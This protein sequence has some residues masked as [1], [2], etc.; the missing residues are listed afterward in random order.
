MRVVKVIGGLGVAAL[1][2][3]APARLSA[4]PLKV[5]SAGSLR[6]ALGEIFAARG[7]TSADQVQSTFGSAGTLRRRLEAGEPADLFLSADMAAPLRLFQSHHGKLAPI[8]FARNTMCVMGSKALGLSAANALDLMLAPDVKLATSLPGADPSGDYAL[9]VFKLAEKVQPGAETRLTA[10]ASHPFG[11]TTPLVPLEG[12]T[13]IGSLFIE[14]KIDLLLSYCSGASDL[15]KDVPD[16]VAVPVPASLDPKP[17]YGLAI[18]SDNPTAAQ[19]ALFIL[20]QDGQAILQ[21]H[22]LKTLLEDEPESR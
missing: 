2:L 11:G 21:R 7:L 10:K 3:G 8:A 13:A 18:L 14:K 16:I 15:T 22:G 1:C 20:S 9:G 4:E 5:Y 6:G 19:L 12:H 17:A